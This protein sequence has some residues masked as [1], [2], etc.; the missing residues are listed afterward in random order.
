MTARDIGRTLAYYLVVGTVAACA[1]TVAPLPFSG[2]AAHGVGI[3]ATAGVCFVG[4]ACAPRMGV[5]P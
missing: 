5:R 2:V 1:A 4:F 3:L